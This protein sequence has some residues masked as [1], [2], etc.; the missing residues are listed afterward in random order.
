MYLYL[1]EGRKITDLGMRHFPKGDWK[2]LTSLSL[3]TNSN[4]KGKLLSVIRR[5][6]TSQN[7]ICPI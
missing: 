5:A 4:I 3:G 7:A 1:K 6:N 2:N